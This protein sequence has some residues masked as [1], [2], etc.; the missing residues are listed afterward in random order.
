MNFAV[1]FSLDLDDVD[2]VFEVQGNFGGREVQIFPQKRFSVDAEDFD[3][4]RALDSEKIFPGPDVELFRSGTLRNRQ[5]VFG[6]DEFSQIVGTGLDVEIRGIVRETDDVV[7]LVGFEISK[8][9]KAEENFPFAEGN[10]F[11]KPRRK[12]DFGRSIEFGSFFDQ[13]GEIA[14]VPGRRGIFDFRFEFWGA[15]RRRGK[16]E[17]KFQNGA[18][19]PLAFQNQGRFFHHQVF[20]ESDVLNFDADGERSAVSDGIDDLRGSEDEA[21][22]QMVPDVFVCR[23]PHCIFRIE[24]FEE[25]RVHVVVVFVEIPESVQVGRV[26]AEAFVGH[27]FRGVERRAFFRIVVIVDEI[28]AVG[29]ISR[30]EPFEKLLA[31]NGIRSPADGAE[32][33]VASQVAVIVNADAFHILA[34]RV[35]GVLEA[36]GM[37]VEIRERGPALLRRILEAHPR[38]DGVGV[39]HSHADFRTRIF[40]KNPQGLAVLLVRS[41]ARLFAAGS[42]HAEFD[43]VDDVL[44]SL[45]RFG[46]LLRMRENRFQRGILMTVAIHVVRNPDDAKA[47]PFAE[48]IQNRMQTFDGEA[49][50]RRGFPERRV[51]GRFASVYRDDGVVG[52]RSEVD[53]EPHKVRIDDSLPQIYETPGMQPEALVGSDSASGVGNILPVV[54]VI[55][56][57]LDERR[58]VRIHGEEED[59]KRNV[60]SHR[61]IQRKNACWKFIPENG[62]ALF[63]N[64]LS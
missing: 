26:R 31:G 4:F 35:R 2:S 9:G 38:G 64:C 54:A 19:L 47:V 1:A 14:P 33:I 7:I 59:E 3:A 23:R 37:D 50:E 46:D 25:R 57:L 8:V 29:G 30:F 24:S 52:K 39:A 43:E 27:V 16:I 51:R 13:I 41:A 42:E 62:N 34:S 63:L 21:V 45:V 10:V 5:N 11:G 20:A 58:R 48:R 17:G 22:A 40:E 44:V 18:V 32:V 36:G 15:E 28:A 6:Q 61:T 56:I 55:E 49:V 60:F 12:F 53:L